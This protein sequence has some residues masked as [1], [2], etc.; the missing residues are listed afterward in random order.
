[1]KEK[2]LQPERSEA[3]SVLVAESRAAAKT[4]WN[5]LAVVY[6]VSQGSWRGGRT[7]RAT[8]PFPQ[9]GPLASVVDVWDPC[10]VRAN[11]HPVAT[12]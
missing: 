3:L 1:M 2:L 8:R 11:T 12:R 9:Q 10:R 4:L 7:L 5:P 6:D